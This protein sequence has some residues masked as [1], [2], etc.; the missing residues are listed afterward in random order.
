MG[1]RETSGW[2]NGD[3]R[4]RPPAKTAQPG[5]TLPLLAPERLRQPADSKGPAS[6]AGRLDLGTGQTT[7]RRTVAGAS[8]TTSRRKR[9][10]RRESEAGATRASLAPQTRSSTSLT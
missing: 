9:S 7:R 2:S 10:K 6:V 1:G 8:P 3:R 4:V 5:T